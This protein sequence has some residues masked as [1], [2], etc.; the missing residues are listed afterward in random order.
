MT[1]HE[2][3]V[4]ADSKDAS[5]VL[6]QLTEKR[7]SY[8][9]SKLEASVDVKEQD[10]EDRL[11]DHNGKEKVL[12][13]AED[14]ATALVSLDDDPTMPLNTFRMWFSGI[15]LAVFGSVLA[16]LFVCSRVSN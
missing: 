13:T 2:E 10:V 14:F 3:V 5:E 8:D 11:Y 4:I 15:G 16:M 6:D 9:D 1:R 7:Y 12:E